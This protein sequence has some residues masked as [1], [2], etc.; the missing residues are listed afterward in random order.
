MTAYD[1]AAGILPV[2]N[3]FM[4]YFMQTWNSSFWIQDDPFD[5][6]PEG[7]DAALQR[8]FPR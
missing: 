7:V 4:F 6:T 3:Q 1:Y 8:A 5:I 2:W